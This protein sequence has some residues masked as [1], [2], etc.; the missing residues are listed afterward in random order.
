MDLPQSRLIK[1]KLSA[2]H[3]AIC[4]QK[5][6]T[7]MYVKESG[8]RVLTGSCSYS[9]TGYKSMRLSWAAPSLN[10]EICA[11]FPILVIIQVNCLGT[12]KPDDLPRGLWFFPVP[13]VLGKGAFF[14]AAAI[15]SLV[16]SES[17]LGWDRPAR[18]FKRYLPL[19]PQNSK[20]G[21]QPEFSLLQHISMCCATLTRSSLNQASP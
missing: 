6:T 14:A 21:P 4:S 9:W 11:V 1:G 12:R 5:V 7:Y 19:L 13:A 10:S 2:E 18:V 3:L 15:N 20:Q 16:S 8:A 17:L